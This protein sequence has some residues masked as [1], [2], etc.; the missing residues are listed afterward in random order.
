M[1]RRFSSMT[2]VS[3]LGPVASLPITSSLATSMTSIT[4]SSP[5]AT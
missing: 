3:G 4:S 5:Q 1:R 2:K